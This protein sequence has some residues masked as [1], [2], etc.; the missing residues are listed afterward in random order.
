MAPGH[1]YRWW[2]TVLEE[3]AQITK[4]ETP[5]DTV[6]S[7]MVHGYQQGGAFV[8]GRAGES[9]DPQQRPV[10]Y[11]KTTLESAGS[12]FLGALTKILGKSL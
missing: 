8:G 3:V 6:Y 2:V 1:G 12:D 4:I 9:G 11:V 5:G 7:Q 10:L